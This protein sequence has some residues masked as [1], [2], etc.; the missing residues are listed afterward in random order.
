MV[1]G[2][3]NTTFLPVFDTCRRSCCRVGRISSSSEKAFAIECCHCL[4]RKDPVGAGR[5]DARDCH[6][7]PAG[8]GSGCNTENGVS[9]KG[10]LAFLKKWL[11][12]HP[13]PSFHNRRSVPWISSSC[14]HDQSGKVSCR[15]DIILERLEF[16][17]FHSL[18]MIGGSHQNHQRKISF[19]WVPKLN[20]QYIQ[21][22]DVLSCWIPER[23]CQELP[24]QSIR[25]Y[26]LAIFCFQE[27]HKINTAIRIMHFH[28]K[29]VISKTP[30][31]SASIPKR[32]TAED[33]WLYYH[34]LDNRWNYRMAEI[35]GSVDPLLCPGL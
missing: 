35:W 25:I 23:I 26:F 4:A 9:S 10:T 16:F 20:K 3:N 21:C 13:T 24:F 12:K 27:P 33:I 17:S 19:L 29:W 8:C 1:K 30:D 6:S 28:C 11:R 2:A 5:K 7:V 18:S 15:W 14:H 31:T 34:T 22:F 32:H